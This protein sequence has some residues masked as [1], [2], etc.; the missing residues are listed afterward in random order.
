MYFHSDLI[1]LTT[2]NGIY[3]FINNFAIFSS[4]IQRFDDTNE[5][6]DARDSTGVHY[7]CTSFKRFYN[8]ALKE[9]NLHG[10][11]FQKARHF[12]VL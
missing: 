9:N 2:A 7:H 3:L 12:A 5:E 4:P 6:I 1:M 11:F 8:A 10:C